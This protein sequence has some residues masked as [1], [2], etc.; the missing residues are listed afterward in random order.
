LIG[1]RE[2]GLV[3]VLV[4]HDRR[5]QIG[6]ADHEFLGHPGAVRDRLGQQL[7]ARDDHGVRLL[8]QP[9]PLFLRDLSQLLAVLEMR[10][11]LGARI[12]VP[13]EHEDSG[14][15]REIDQDQRVMRAGPQV[16][17][18]KLSNVHG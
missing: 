6:T 17:R 11:A 1:E 5:F 14:N 18:R 8:E 13:R 7:S 15:Q 2:E 4:L 9:V 10:G 3:Q 16:E 12:R